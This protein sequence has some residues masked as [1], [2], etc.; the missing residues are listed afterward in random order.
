M[1]QPQSAQDR[2]IVDLFDR[3][4]RISYSLQF[5]EGLNPAQWIALRYL[6][7]AK[8]DSSSP[9]AL[10]AFMNST[11]GTVSQ[12]L[13][14]LEDKGLVERRRRTGDRRG[15][16]V[17]VTPHGLELLERDPL[18]TI[19]DAVSPCSDM[20]RESFVSDLKHLLDALLSH[21]GFAEFGSCPECRY[22]VVDDPSCGNRCGVTGKPVVAAELNGICT[23]FMRGG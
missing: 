9:G 4:G 1:P 7:R 12:T 2:R 23:H 13:K 14:S 17:A 15:V 3:L 18:A 20:E 10:A 5:A 11:K 6:A 21:H 19:P 22:L 16:H 8:P